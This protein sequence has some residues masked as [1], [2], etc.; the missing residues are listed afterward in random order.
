MSPLW[1]RKEKSLQFLFISPWCLTYF[2]ASIASYLSHIALVLYDFVLLTGFAIS[3]NYHGEKAVFRLTG[4]TNR[5]RTINQISFYKS[6]LTY[7]LKNYLYRVVCIK[8]H[9]QV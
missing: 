9:I 5:S 1:T 2:P 8:S 3:V 6:I 7:W 4:G